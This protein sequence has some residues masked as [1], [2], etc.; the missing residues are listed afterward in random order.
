MKDVSIIYVENKHLEE[1]SDSLEATKYMDN[2]ITY[3][4]SGTGFDDIYNDLKD[5]EDVKILLKSI[6]QEL[7]EDQKNVIILKFWKN[8]NDDEIGYELNF[9]RKKVRSLLE[10]SFSYIRDRILSEMY[11][12][13]DE[14]A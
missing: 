7:P 11:E 1:I 3:D 13:I 4:E 2:K 14:I 10:K 9:S 5:S 8:F 12:T 6:V